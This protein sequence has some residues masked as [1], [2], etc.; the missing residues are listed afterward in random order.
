MG[1]IT[2]RIL[3]H[4]LWA[5]ATYAST[6]DPAANITNYF[7][8]NRLLTPNVRSDSGQPDAW[9]DYQQI[10]SELGLIVST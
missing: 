7:I 6:D 5:G 8:A 4:I 1:V 10:L 2:P 3:Y 9:R